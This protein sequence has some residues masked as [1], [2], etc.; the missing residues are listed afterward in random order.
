[1][2]G[3]ECL[4][5]I[6]TYNLETSYLLDP[7]TA[8]GVAAYEKCNAPSEICVTLATAHPA[9]FNE[10]I[11]RC[12]IQQTFPEQISQLSNKPQYLEVVEADKGEVVRHLEKLFSFTAK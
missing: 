1:V 9:K 8:C 6:S 2:K 4:Q 12:D 5:T 11:E 7:H 10:S 3:E